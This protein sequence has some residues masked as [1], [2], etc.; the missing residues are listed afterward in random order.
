[1]LS[2]AVILFPLM[3]SLLMAQYSAANSEHVTMDMKREEAERL[4]AEL[5]S[6]KDKI[7]G[8]LREIDNMVKARYYS[9]QEASKGNV[10]QEV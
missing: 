10:K 2:H 8:L 4:Q 5:A 6:T 3:A 9:E 1:M 7:N